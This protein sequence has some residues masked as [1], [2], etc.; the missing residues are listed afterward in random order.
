MRKKQKRTLR[1]MF[2]QKKYVHSYLIVLFLLF[3]FL[4]SIAF[5]VPQELSN[6]ITGAVISILPID[7]PQNETAHFI[8]PSPEITIPENP[9]TK[10]QNP[11]PAASVRNP[12]PEQPINLEKNLKNIKQTAE[13]RDY[14]ELD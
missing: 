14:E 7:E 10:V 9:A 2:L 4:L 13:E 12:S 8:N 5:I 6:S 1:R 3:L 11:S